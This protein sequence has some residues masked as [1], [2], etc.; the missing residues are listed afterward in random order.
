MQPS[1]AGLLDREVIF[2]DLEATSPKKVF[3]SLSRAMAERHGLEP[4][5]VLN[6][7]LAREKLGS[8]AIGHGVIVPHARIAGLTDPT[9]GFAK[10]KEPVDFDAMDEQKCDLV[11]LLLAPPEASAAHL[12]ALARIAR[13][14]RLP[15]Y[16]ES[17]RQAGSV[18][19][20]TN[21]LH[22]PE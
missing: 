19:G 22:T 13:V 15:E 14:M 4:R 2:H 17:L 12:R 10:L 16:R 6:A 1:L 7:V 20:L 5:E 9:G 11:V 21:L 18:E 8:T 3:A